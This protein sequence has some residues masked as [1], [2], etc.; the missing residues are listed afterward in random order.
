MTTVFDQQGEP[1]M[2]VTLFSTTLDDFVSAKIA[3][4][5]A[6]QDGDVAAESEAETVA[7][8]RLQELTALLPNG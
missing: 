7:A 4:D 6:R 2:N 1:T 5:N 8:A 3:A